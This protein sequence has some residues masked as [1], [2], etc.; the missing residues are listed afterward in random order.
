MNITNDMDVIDSRDIIERLEALD[1]SLN[2]VYE[3]DVDN[4]LSFDE[5][6]ELNHDNHELGIAEYLALQNI[7]D[8]LENYVDDWR[9][10][11]IL[12]HE[13]YF[14]EYMDE[15]VEDLYGFSKD[16]PEWATITYDYEA[17]KQDYTE[18]DFNG[19]TYYVR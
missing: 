1:E 16:L 6:L 11:A 4:P 3:C 5:W 8:Q 14:H 15:M 10:G 17:L 12:I 2:D 7:Q 13:D 9:F 18:I 19:V